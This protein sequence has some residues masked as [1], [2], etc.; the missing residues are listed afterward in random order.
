MIKQT[1]VYL[2]ARITSA[3][4]SLLAVALTTHLLEPNELG[5]CNLAY[6]AASLGNSLLFTWMGYVLWR[7]YPSCAR[8]GTERGLIK[9]LLK[10]SIL[11]ILLWICYWALSRLMLPG[12]RV[13]IYAIM[14]PLGLLLGAGEQVQALLQIQGRVRESV[15]LTIV[16]SVG[17]ISAGSLVLFFGWRSGEGYLL[18][19]V[20]VLAACVAWGALLCRL[21]DQSPLGAG[22]IPVREMLVFGLPQTFTSICALLLAIGDRFLIE[23]YQGTGAVAIYHTAYNL[24]DMA[25]QIPVSAVMQAAVPAIIASW[26]TGREAASIKINDAVRL[27]FRIVL[28]VTC[29]AMALGPLLGQLLLGPKYH[30]SLHI[31]P[32]ICLGS[33]FFGFTKIL[34]M[35]LQLEKRPWSLVGLLAAGAVINLLLNIALLPWL[36]VRG[37][38]LATVA[39]FGAYLYLSWKTVAPLIDAARTSLLPAGVLEWLALGFAVAYG[40]LSCSFA[41]GV[42]QPV[43]LTAG[44]VGAALA[45]SILIAEL[46]VSFKTNPHHRNS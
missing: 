46:R 18:A 43:V 32:A 38:V 28:P 26:E 45:V 29:L 35:P 2:I 34:N 13:S 37:A 25:V 40:L 41:A 17:L 6:S 42:P 23:I 3:A 7:F 1:G 8:E 22:R 33:W 11:V 24:G 9:W 27:L 14:L 30:Q 21:P 12:L 5:Q 16:Q 31:L 36:G 10:S 15:I 39:A 44:A 19:N 4:S 20:G